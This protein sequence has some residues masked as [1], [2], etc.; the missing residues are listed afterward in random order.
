MV[1]DLR[2]ARD[3]ALR[4]RDDW[5]RKAR[6]ADQR[7]SKMR[8]EVDERKIAN[9]TVEQQLKETESRRQADRA[10]H[11][12]ELDAIKAQVQKYHKQTQYQQQE[13]EQRI[14][15]LKKKL[16]HYSAGMVDAASS[17]LE[18]P[19][20]AAS[21]TTPGP[22]MSVDLLNLELNEAQQQVRR[23]RGELDASAKMAQALQGEK[24]ELLQQNRASVVRCRE[25]LDENGCLRH[26]IRQLREDVVAARVANQAAAA[27]PA[28]LGGPPVAASATGATGPTGHVFGVAE[29][30]SHSDMQ[31]AM[32]PLP[33]VLSPL[34][35]HWK[36]ASKSDVRRSPADPRKDRSSVLQQAQLG[37]NYFETTSLQYQLD[38]E[39]RHS[40]T[41]AAQL[42]EA[43][44]NEDRYRR[45][46]SDLTGQQAD[47]LRQIEIE[48]K[49]VAEAD[50]RAARFE[51]QARHPLLLFLCFILH[52]DIL[53]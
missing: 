48:A 46:L 38:E 50:T 17:W 12:Q 28:R 32:P 21:A 33:A 42:R 14:V 31:L 29:A 1:E 45:Q 19:L 44:K 16:L 13:L 9:Q 51:A 2:L 23:L 10:A 39:Q 40:T 24:Y 7:V 5:A 35:S 11:G 26:E 20:T 22:L 4:D 36:P 53:S 30:F 27:T 15:V 6:A 49:R 34:V 18:R 25:L 47:Y 43:Q 41:L 3:Q 37:Q 52:R 8:N